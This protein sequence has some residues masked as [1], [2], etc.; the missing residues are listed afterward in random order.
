MEMHHV[1]EHCGGKHYSQAV[2]SPNKALGA[3]HIFEH[4]GGITTQ[5]QQVVPTRH[6]ERTT[7]LSIV[8]A[9]DQIKRHIRAIGRHFYIETHM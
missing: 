6:R 2:S 5:R 8:S 1:F 9:V 7:S 3:H 4:C